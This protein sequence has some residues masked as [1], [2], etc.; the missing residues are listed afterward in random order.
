VP[1][2]RAVPLRCPRVYVGAPACLRAGVPACRR[3][4][5]V[6]CLQ[7]TELKQLLDSERAKLSQLR[8]QAAEAATALEE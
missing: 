4:W 5:L 3:A 1:D 8:Q 7:V 2:S 6:S